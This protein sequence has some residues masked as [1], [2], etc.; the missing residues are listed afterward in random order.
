MCPDDPDPTPQTAIN[1]NTGFSCTAL[2]LWL[3][4]Q[5]AFL[6]QIIVVFIIFLHQLSLQVHGHILPNFSYSHST[7][8]PRTLRRSKTVV[9]DEGGSKQTYCLTHRVP[10]CCVYVWLKVFNNIC[11]DY[12]SDVISPNHFPFLS[13]CLFSV[14]SVSLAVLR[15]QKGEEGCL[16]KT[17]RR[18]SAPVNT[19]KPTAGLDN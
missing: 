18:V 10:V 3:L 19:L 13:F 2:S 16:F 4:F 1:R 7:N 6:K 12:E 17:P 9:P 14:V 11:H 5:C 8:P 15:V